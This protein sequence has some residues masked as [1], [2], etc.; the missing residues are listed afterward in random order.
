MPNYRRWLVPGATYF[1]TLATRYRRPLFD[2]ESVPMPGAA[3]RKVKKDRPFHNFAMAVLPDHLHCVCS[4]PAGD[5]DYST[6]W[7]LVKRRFA[8]LWLQSGQLETRIPDARRARGERGIWQPRFWEHLIRNDEDMQRCC[9]YIH[10]NSIKHGYV[11][12]PADW[13][14]STY[15]RFE[16]SGHYPEGWGAVEPSSLT[17]DGREFGE[18]S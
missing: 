9:G 10:Y 17:G 3:L 7:R 5:T 2:E 12:K 6:R 4:L 8:L 1:F 11:T 14:W 13:P 15:S 16:R 18:W